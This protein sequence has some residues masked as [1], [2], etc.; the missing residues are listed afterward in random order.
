MNFHHLANGNCNEQLNIL[1]TYI[2]DYLVEKKNH[3]LTFFFNFTIIKFAI[4]HYSSTPHV[5]TARNNNIKLG[6]TRGPFAYCVRKIGNAFCEGNCF[7][8]C[9]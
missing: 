5:S 9:V 6:G 1:Y 8:Q 4:L 7:A 3:S 2:I